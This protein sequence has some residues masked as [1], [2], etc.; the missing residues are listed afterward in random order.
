MAGS[1]LPPLTAENSGTRCSAKFVVRA[2]LLIRGEVRSEIRRLAF[3]RDVE[4]D[5]DED[6]GWIESDFMVRLRGRHRD[7]RAIM[8][9]VRSMVESLD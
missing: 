5:L 7:V 8:S 3:K 9:S 4:L 2:G 1:A 6:K